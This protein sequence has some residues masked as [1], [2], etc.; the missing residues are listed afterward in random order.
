VLPL[1]FTGKIPDTYPVINGHAA[2]VLD[3][4]WHPFNDFIVAS[5]SE[6]TKVVS[7]LDG[8]RNPSRFSFSL[9]STLIL[10]PFIRRWCGGSRKADLP[11]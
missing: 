6:D 3:T 1:T 7:F 9:D 4:D 11:S 5:G 8:S 10:D 2:A